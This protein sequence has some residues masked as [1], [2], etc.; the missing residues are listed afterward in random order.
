M[1]FLA[2]GALLSFADALGLGLALGL[3]CGFSLLII[4]IVSSSLASDLSSVRCVKD[5]CQLEEWTKEKKFD[6]A[7]GEIKNREMAIVA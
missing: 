1:P 4:A 6:D 2:S 3:Y 5:D 7:G